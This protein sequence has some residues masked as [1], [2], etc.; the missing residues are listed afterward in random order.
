MKFIAVCVFGL[1]KFP[2]AL[3]FITQVLQQSRS[4]L[5]VYVIFYKIFSY[6]KEKVFS[7]S[8]SFK[9]FAFDAK[10]HSFSIDTH[11]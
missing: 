9:N 7:Q 6:I 8:F 11:H 10:M 2:E 4:Y 3:Q 5:V 1:K